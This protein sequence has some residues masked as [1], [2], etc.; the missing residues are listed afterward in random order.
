MKKWIIKWDTGY[1]E[2]ADI[3]EAA[4]QTKAVDE[5]YQSALEEFENSVSYSAEPYSQEE[6]EGY[7]LE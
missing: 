7:G 5:A 4:D 1:G 6:A 3:I 2:M